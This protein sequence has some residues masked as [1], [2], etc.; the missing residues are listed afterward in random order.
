MGRPPLP[1][2]PPLRLL[3]VLLSILL[4]PPLLLA[5]IAAGAGTRRAREPRPRGA[6]REEGRGCPC[7]IPRGCGGRPLPQGCLLP[8]PLR[9]AMGGVSLPLSVSPFS[10]VPGDVG[11]PAL[12]GIL[13]TLT[14]GVGVL[15]P[16]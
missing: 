16:E 12:R 10:P 15:Y 4:P 5:G 13:P 6:G 14:A 8:A 11:V 1:P 2:P 7:P 9:W 3:L